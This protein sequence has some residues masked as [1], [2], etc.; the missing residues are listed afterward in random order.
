MDGLTATLS[1]LG[2]WFWLIAAVL[3]FILEAILPGVFLLWFG[4]AAAVVGIVAVNVEMPLLWQLV[5]FGVT[6]VAS[7]VAAR[8]WLRY[9]EPVTDPGSLNIRGQQYVGQVFVLETAIAN[10]RG[11]MR[12][13][14][15][16]WSVQ[17]PD[18][19]AGTRVRVSGADGIILIVTAAT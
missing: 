1:E 13:G 6:A 9:G 15:T 4:L 18:L 8:T 2:A 7:V 19:P 10:G 5:L 3:L 11:R 17:G 12:V 16:L 14:D